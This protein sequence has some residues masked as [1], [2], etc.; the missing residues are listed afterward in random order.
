MWSAWDQADL[1]LI[2]T[3]SSTRADG[4]LVMGAG[5][6]R[7]A[8]DRFP[9][10]DARLGQVIQN[11]AAART[12]FSH[13][14]REY[15]SFTPPYCL[16]VSPNWPQGKLGLFQVKHWFCDHANLDLIECSVSAL[17]RW[18]SEHP[19]ARV[20]VNF[21]GIGNG[22]LDS[23]DVLPLISQLPDSV[24][25]WQY[26]SNSAFTRVVHC[27]REPC[28]VY[29]GRPS[30]WGNPFRVGPDGTRQEVIAKYRA[31]IVQQPKLMRALSEL[32]GKT[33]GCWCKPEACHG[34]VLVELIERLEKRG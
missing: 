20:H 23:G 33:L 32:A 22:R 6:A 14:G 29:I 24:D 8:R 2:T 10:L 9:G 26:R 21:P 31:W 25:V 30:K 4:R 16:L 27:K 12:R 5:I 7:Q 11:Q 18:C 15:F 34:D 17:R 28:D 1:F 13:R 19:D 3:N